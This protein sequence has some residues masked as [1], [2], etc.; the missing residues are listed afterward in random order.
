MDTMANWNKL[1]EHNC[2]NEDA[3]A[4]DWHEAVTPMANGEAAM[5]LMG[6]FIRDQVRSTA[7][8]MLEDLDF[9]QFPIINPDVAIGEDAP[10]DGWFHVR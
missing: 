3:S 8:E 10:T 1:F 7:P 6:D 2:F 5:Y 9:F 4:L